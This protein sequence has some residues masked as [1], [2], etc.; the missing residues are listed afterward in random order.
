VDRFPR[1]KAFCHVCP[2]DSN[3]MELECES[4]TE[5]DGISQFLL[6]QHRNVIAV[7]EPQSLID[8]LNKTAQKIKF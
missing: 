5:F 3:I 6:G 7:I 8:K 2:T 4:N 1:T